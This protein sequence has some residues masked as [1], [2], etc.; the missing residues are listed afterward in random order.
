[1]GPY[2]IAN[3]VGRLTSQYAGKTA[4][5]VGAAV[6]NFSYDPMGRVIQSAECWG[7]LECASY[8]G[9]RSMSFTF[10]LAGN[11]VLMN[12]GASRAFTFGYDSSGRL[13]TASNVFAG[14]SPN[15]PM[16]MVTGATYYPSGQVQSMT[17]NTGPQNDNRYMG[18]R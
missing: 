17:D 4:T 15:I 7:A 14:V 13:I 12:N 3:G 8:A 1:M 16:P 6:R 9:T 18:S 2:T 11:R 5:G 10:D